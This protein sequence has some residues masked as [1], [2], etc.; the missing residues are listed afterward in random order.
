MVLYFGVSLSVQKPAKSGVIL[1]FTSTNYYQR[2][3]SK[4]IF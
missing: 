2:L 3:L 4:L 1:K